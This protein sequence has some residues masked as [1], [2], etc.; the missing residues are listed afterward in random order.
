[1]LLFEELL[2]EK[3]GM[4]VENGESRELWFAGFDWVEVRNDD[5]VFLNEYLDKILICFF[6]AGMFQVVGILC[7]LA[8]YNA[9]LVDFHFPL[10]LYK[11]LLNQNVSLEDFKTLSPTEG[12]SLEQ[13]LDYDGDDIEDVFSLAFEVG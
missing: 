13:L 1:M 12:R 3:Y 9:V 2:H 5:V 4:F 11:K 6:Q 7:G 8:I 10:A